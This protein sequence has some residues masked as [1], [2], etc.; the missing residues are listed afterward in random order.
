MNWFRKKEV[1]KTKLEL[2][3]E[4]NELLFAE[5]LNLDYKKQISRKLA[6]KPYHIFKYVVVSLGITGIDPYKVGDYTKQ[7][8]D[9]LNQ[10]KLYDKI[11]IIPVIGTNTKTTIVYQIEDTQGYIEV[12]SVNL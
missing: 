4:E 3:Q 7:I 9:I 2:L 11:V 10:S 8:R 1:V 6:A 5:H 12:K